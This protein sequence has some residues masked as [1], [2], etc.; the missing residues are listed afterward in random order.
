M[1]SPAEITIPQDLLPADGRFGAGP[2]ARHLGIVPT[3]G[4]EA[5][6]DEVDGAPADSSVAALVAGMERGLLVTD[7]W[8]TRVLDPRTLSI[9]GLT[10]NGVWLVEDGQVTA[11]V[12][13][14]RFTQSYAAA[15]APG[16]VLAVGRTATPVPGDTYTATSPRFSSPALHLAAW[17]FTGGASG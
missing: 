9:T 15:L 6:A 2:S 10:R 7:F 4:F 3:A 1:T 17:N 8:Y 14:F 11:P 13:N 12:K 5:V 16:N